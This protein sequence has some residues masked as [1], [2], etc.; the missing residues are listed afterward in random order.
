M[1][2]PGRESCGAV[3]SILIV[4]EAEL[5]NPALFVAE[6]VKV[7][8]VVSAVRFEGEQPFEER[9]PDSLSVTDQVTFTL[10][11]YQ[12]FEPA[13]PVFGMMPGGVLSVIT[14]GLKQPPTFPVQL[15]GPGFNGT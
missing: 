12:P 14:A 1:G 6:Q 15:V 4:T 5:V 2:F 8:P 11:L 13:V 3:L 9:I 7:V 10:L